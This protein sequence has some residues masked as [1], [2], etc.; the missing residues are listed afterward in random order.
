MDGQS[1]IGL[2]STIVQV[3]DGIPHILRQ[4]SISS[5][6]IRKVVEQFIEN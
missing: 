1:K 5:E 4:G 2:A 6:Q 3:I